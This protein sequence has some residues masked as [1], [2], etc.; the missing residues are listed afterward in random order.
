MVDLLQ[1]RDIVT[2]VGSGR[3]LDHVD[4]RP[5]RHIDVCNGVGS[6]QAD[7][8]A[9][10]LQIRSGVAGGQTGEALVKQ[11]QHLR[12]P[13]WFLHRPSGAQGQHHAQFGTSHG[14]G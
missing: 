11:V 8:L 5:V 7:K 14:R 10:I 13:A 1:L 2:K 3:T 4:G 9:Q 12:G 6:I